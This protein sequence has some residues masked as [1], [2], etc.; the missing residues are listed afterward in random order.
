MIRVLG[1]D[2]SSS[3][4]GWCVIDYDNQ[5]ASLIDYGHI[6]P[7]SKAKAKGVLPYRLNQTIGL[8]ENVV[9]KYKPDEV[10]VE[11]YAKKFSVG[12]SRAST[13]IIL[14]VFNELCCLIG[15]KRTGKDAYRYPVSKIRKVIGNHFGIKTVSK[16][17]I[18]PVITSSCS[19]FKTQKNKVGN[20]KKECGDE[21]DAIAV[22]ITHVLEK[23]SNSLIWSL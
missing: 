11:D 13:I 21:A 1:L 23:S 18:F 14:A 22:A 20:I 6:K 19:K 16:D 9:N 15:Y 17:D 10:A 2:I 4:I 5:S 3:T 8:M 7:P 12:R